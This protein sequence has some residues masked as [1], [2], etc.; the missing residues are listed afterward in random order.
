MHNSRCSIYYTDWN[1]DRESWKFD[2]FLNI[3]FCSTAKL[4]RCSYFPVPLGTRMLTFL[5]QHITQS[6]SLQTSLKFVYCQK[7]AFTI[8]TFHQITHTQPFNGLWSG[9]TQVGRY[10]KKQILLNF[11]GAGEYNGGRGTDSLGG[12]HH[13]RTN[14]APLPPQPP[15]VF[16]T[17]QMP[18][19]PP[20]Q[21]RQSSEGTYFH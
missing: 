2:N 7:L 19:L 12:R 9:T 3:H 16:F 8:I 18:F 17:G 5:Q 20:N 13:N 10:Q 6:N 14:G 11:C 4:S 15:K 1:T 21:Q